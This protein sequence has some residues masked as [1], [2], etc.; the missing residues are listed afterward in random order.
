MGV[1]EWGNRASAPCGVNARGAVGSS[2]R[3]IAA[4]NGYTPEKYE[5]L[6]RSPAEAG[7]GAAVQRWKVQEKKGRHMLMVLTMITQRITHRRRRW[8]RCHYTDFWMTC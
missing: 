2:M 8:T 7:G 3:R 1:P 6:R 4:R 5:G